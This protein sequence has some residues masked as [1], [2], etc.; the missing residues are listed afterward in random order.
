MGLPDSAV[1]ERLVVPA[2]ADQRAVASHPRRED[3][4]GFGPVNATAGNSGRGAATWPARRAAQRG[5]LAA[6]AVQ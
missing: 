3:C 2:G 4:T 5:V 6:I 1:A